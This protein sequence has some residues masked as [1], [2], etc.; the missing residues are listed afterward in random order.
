MTPCREHQGVLNGDGYGLVWI[1]SRRTYVMAHRVAWEQAKGPIPEGMSVLHRCDNRPCVNPDHLFLG[2]RADNVADMIA[3]GR[4]RKARGDAS[5]RR[6][7]PESWAAYEPVGNRAWYKLRDTDIPVIRARL[8]RDETDEAIA[9]DYRV[10][11]LTIRR[12]ALGE[13][14]SRV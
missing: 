1:K 3:K 6:R 5:G 13:T 4:D 14:W 11:P 10:T 7:H 9:L 12:I 8:S 2:T